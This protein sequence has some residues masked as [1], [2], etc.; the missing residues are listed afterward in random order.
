LALE[1]HSQEIFPILVSDLGRNNPLLTTQLLITVVRQT[2]TNMKLR[3]EDI[4]LAVS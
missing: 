2:M 3:D 4:T 1:T